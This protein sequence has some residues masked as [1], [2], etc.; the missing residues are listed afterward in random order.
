MM[1]G[2]LNAVDMSRQSYCL[3]DLFKQKTT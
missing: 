1:I 2:F 3:A